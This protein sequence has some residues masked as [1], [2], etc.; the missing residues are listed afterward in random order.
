MSRGLLGW[1]DGDDLWVIQ[2]EEV[3]EKTGMSGIADEEERAISTIG[4]PTAGIDMPMV[5]YT[6][7]SI[8]AP[9]YLDVFAPFLHSVFT[10]HPPLR[11][12]RPKYL[13]SS[14]D[15]LDRFRKVSACRHVL[16]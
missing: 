5:G 14:N 8:P 4:K 15:P 9:S 12:H 13:L 7:N 16:G 6:A 2:L 3:L 10:T 11:P 1:R